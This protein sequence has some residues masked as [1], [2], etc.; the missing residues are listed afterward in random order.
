MGS[1]GSAQKKT[2]KE[3]SSPDAEPIIVW[4]YRKVPEGTNSKYD[5]LAKDYGDYVQ[6]KFPGLKTYCYCPMEGSQV[7]NDVQ[8]FNSVGTFRGHMFM[9]PLDVTGVKKM[10]NFTSATDPSYNFRGYVFGAWEQTSFMG[11]GIPKMF[12]MMPPDHPAWFEFREQAAGF[13]K[14]T[15]ASSEKPPILIM[16]EWLANDGE[17]EDIVAMWQEASDELKKE[18]KVIAMW[19][20]RECLRFKL[21]DKD[22][23]RNP[24]KLV[25]ISAFEDLETFNSALALFKDK[26]SALKAHMAAPLTA[27]I[28]AEDATDDV[29]KGMKEFDE[30]GKFTM[31]KI[32]GRGWNNHSGGCTPC[33]ECK[34][35]EDAEAKALCE[36][37]YGK[38]D[39]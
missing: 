24:N 32:E 8:W 19:L 10:L 39:G 29:L 36:Q 34:V 5:E 23:T 28:W 26:A 33:D 30:N 7:V 15:P 13:I 35:P 3:V 37:L 11:M 25:A 16:S 6:P 1:G 38:L 18:A 12:G 17:S 27:E 21:R 31:F 2:G 4:S 14:N 9:N 22:K 20:S